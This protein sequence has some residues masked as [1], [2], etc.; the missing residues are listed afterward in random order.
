MSIHS[1]LWAAALGALS[2]PRDLETSITLV[3]ELS[4]C[5]HGSLEAW[6]RVR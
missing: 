4:W 6:A 2:I 1:G 5:D 3:G